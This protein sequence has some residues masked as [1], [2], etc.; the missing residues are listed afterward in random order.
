MA[1]PT[2]SG[3]RGEGDQIK[4]I[5]GAGSAQINAGT[6]GLASIAVLLAS[7]ENAYRAEFVLIGDLS[8][9][10]GAQEGAVI[11]GRKKNII[12]APATDAD[13]PSLTNYQRPVAFLPFDT[14][15]TT[16]NVFGVGNVERDEEY[17]IYLQTA[18]ANLLAGHDLYYRPLGPV[19][20]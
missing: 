19:A 1:L 14:N 20:K 11:Y 9:P 16:I 5:D 8:F 6:F 4:I 15:P 17:Y 18:T 13:V 12:A 10:A 2:G 7:S 3:I